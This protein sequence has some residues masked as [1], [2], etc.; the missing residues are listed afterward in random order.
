MIRPVNF[1]AIKTHVNTQYGD[2]TGVIQIDGFDNITSIYEL[3]ADYDFDTS[4]KF[5]VGFGLSETTTNGVGRQGNAVCHILYLDESKCGNN[6][7]EINQRIK[8]KDTLK[9]KRKSFFITYSEFK[10]Y[11]KRYDFVVTSELTQNV[12]DIEIEEV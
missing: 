9:L 12:S 5:I 8:E 1:D 2:L 4:G 6:F 10:K 11:I 7:D 3:C